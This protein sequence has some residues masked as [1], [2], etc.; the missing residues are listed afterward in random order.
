MHNITITCKF[1]IEN[2]VQLMKFEVSNISCLTVW[3]RGLDVSLVSE[4]HVY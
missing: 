3:Y 4:Y 1:N 2:E